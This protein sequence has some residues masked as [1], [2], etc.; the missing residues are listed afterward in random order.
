M[1]H[2]IVICGLVVCLSGIAGVASAQTAEKTRRDE[3]TFG[4]QFQ[5]IGGDD[6]TNMPKGGFAELAI[7]S[8]S[9]QGVLQIGASFKSA[10]D[11]LTVGNTTY[12]SDG[13][14]QA[15]RLMGG[16]RG[17][18]RG[19]GVIGYGHALAGVFRAGFSSTTIISGPSGSTTQKFKE[20]ESKF[21]AQLGAGVQI[22]AGDRTHVRIG[23]DYQRVFVEGGGNVFLASVGFG[24]RVGR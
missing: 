12:S 3:V 21:S 1:R 6:G 15:M 13:S 5:R 8:S 16:V 24:F 22:P 4:Y 19:N 2:V 7:G 9:F 10:D 11:S 23:V 14:L 20:F 17:R 18:S